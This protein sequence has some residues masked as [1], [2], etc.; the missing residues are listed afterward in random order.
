MFAGT[1]VDHR[2]HL[3]R[4]RDVDVHEGRVDVRVAHRVDGERTAR[5]HRVGDP[6]PGTL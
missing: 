3:V 4:L 1:R 6:D 5:L 2:R